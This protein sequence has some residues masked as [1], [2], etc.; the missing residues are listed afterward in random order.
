MNRSNLAKSAFIS[1]FQNEYFVEEILGLIKN[2]YEN[3]PIEYE[4]HITL[5]IEILS[6]VFSESNKACDL[7]LL[8]YGSDMFDNLQK[9][10][11]KMLQA[12]DKTDKD[13]VNK[14]FYHKFESLLNFLQP[15]KQF[16]ESKEIKNLMIY[17]NDCL[18]DNLQKYNLNEKPINEDNLKEESTKQYVKSLKLNILNYNNSD[19]GFLESLK[20]RNSLITR[21]YAAVKIVN[22]SVITIFNVFIMSYF[23]KVDF[24]SF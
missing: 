20:N 23:Y 12:Y 13:P 19:A 11:T 6:S 10:Q 15:V 17:I 18:F 9:L 24:L 5:L 4:A 8:L 21:V 3:E 1:L 2:Y 22:L 16:S 7:I 14:E